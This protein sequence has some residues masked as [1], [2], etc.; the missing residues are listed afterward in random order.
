NLGTYK[1]WSFFTSGFLVGGIG[2]VIFACFIL[3]I[4]N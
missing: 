2:G 4:P 1:D 3:L